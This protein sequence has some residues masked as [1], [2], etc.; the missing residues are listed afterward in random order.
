MS[1]KYLLLALVFSSTAMAKKLPL[2]KFDR[3]DLNAYLT[4]VGKDKELKRL[5][6]RKAGK[7]DFFVVADTNKKGKSALDK[8][9]FDL[10]RDGNLDI[11]K[12]FENGQV[13]R[14]EWSLDSDDLVDTIKFHN[15]DTGDVYLKVE[16]IG[17]MV[18]WSHFFKSKLRKKEFDRDADL[19]PDMWYFYRN[20]KLVKAEARK[21]PGS[22]KIVDITSTLKIK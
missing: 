21:S 1:P 2:P 4:Q 6:S 22:K 18:V 16:R 17:E 8:H 3:I 14:S 20:E 12:H 7:D 11:A 9:L 19:K 15:K 13:V 5:N 10:D